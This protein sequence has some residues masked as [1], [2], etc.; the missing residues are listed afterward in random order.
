MYTYF[1]IGLLE[2]RDLVALLFLGLWPAYG[3]SWFV[4]S[5]SK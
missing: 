4:C 3:L 2:K 1:N 5:S